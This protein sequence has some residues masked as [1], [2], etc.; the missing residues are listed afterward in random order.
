MDKTQFMSE[1]RPIVTVAGNHAGCIRKGNASA[2]VRTHYFE[3]MT[4]VCKMCTDNFSVVPDC[5]KSRLEQLCISL[6][7]K[8]PSRE[9]VSA[10]EKYAK[11]LGFRL[12]RKWVRQDGRMISVN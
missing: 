4:K 3:L 1:L 9:F 7:E 2:A 5:I 12:Y 6:M 8:Q 10:A 11:V